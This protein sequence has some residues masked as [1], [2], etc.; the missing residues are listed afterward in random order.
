MA[1]A[2]ERPKCNGH[3]KTFLRMNEQPTKKKRGGTQPGSGRPPKD[4]K[5]TVI[6]CK[7][8]ITQAHHAATEGDRSGMIRRALEWYPKHEIDYCIVGKVY[9][10][11]F[12]TSPYGETYTLRITFEGG[13][14]CAILRQ[15]VVTLF[16]LGDTI[17]VTSFKGETTIEVLTHS[18]K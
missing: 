8:S 9:N 6:K 15:K 4:P 11:Y 14:E 17:K 1:K 16:S 7:I 18:K 13:A 2:S 12:E 5:D 10:A 3:R